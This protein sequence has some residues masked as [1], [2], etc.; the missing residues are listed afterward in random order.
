MS[1]TLKK[2]RKQVRVYVDGPDADNLDA[3]K[4]ST[5]QTDTWIINTLLSAALATA[6]ENGGFRLPLRFQIEEE[7]AALR[8]REREAPLPK[9][10]AA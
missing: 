10:K 8:P 5:G 3:L 2:E 7:A 1:T 4:D 6:R 9:R